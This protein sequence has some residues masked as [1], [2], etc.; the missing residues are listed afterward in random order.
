MA[1]VL[2]GGTK[3]GS[4]KSTVATNLAV[5]RA[6]AGHDVL[7]VDADEQESSY[8]FT[9]L[10]NQRRSEQGGGAGYTCI[11]LTGVAVRT[12]LLRLRSKYREIVIDAGGRDTTGQRAAMTVADVLLIPFC[13]RS[14]DVWTVAKMGQIVE[15]MR[16]AN[17]AL[18]A[19]TFLS[20]ADS[21]GSENDEATELLKEAPTFTLLNTPLGY[22]KAFGH[23][24]A[25]GLAVTELESV[26]ELRRKYDPKAAT[27]VEA[28]YQAVYEAVAPT[29]TLWHPEEDIQAAQGV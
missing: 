3:G 7:L 18:S 12:E 23:A 19:L 11:K 2:I 1:V 5:L 10:R 14:F 22:R 26:P 24:A 25:F 4:G 28:L 29:A 16:A 13:P 21:V 20:K 6:A 9:V 17:P 8:D 15:E 27:E